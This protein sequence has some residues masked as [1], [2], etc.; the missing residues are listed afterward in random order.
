MVDKRS[1]RGRI[2]VEYAGIGNCSDVN[3][4]AAGTDRYIE[5]ADG[6]LEVYTDGLLNCT[7]VIAGSGNIRNDR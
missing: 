3:G 7:V 2:R 5:V 1:S 6:Y 4:S